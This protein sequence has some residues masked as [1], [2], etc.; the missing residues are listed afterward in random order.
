MIE[1]TFVNIGQ[2]RRVKHTLREIVVAFA[3]STRMT[4][5][6]SGCCLGCVDGRRVAVGCC[7]SL[8]VGAVGDLR[9]RAHQAI[10]RHSST[11]PWPLSP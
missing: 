3:L 10:G 1:L 6:S 9:S 2:M 8:H 11:E 4:H 7:L 5:L